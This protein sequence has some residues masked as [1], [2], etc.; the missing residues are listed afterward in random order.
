MGDGA[1]AVMTIPLEPGLEVIGDLHLD[2]GDA[3]ECER[4]ATWLGSRGELKRL[5]SWATSSMHGWGR[6]RREWMAP[7][8]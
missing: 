5:S 8:R 4:F 3:G 7:K 1:E 2:P 6:R